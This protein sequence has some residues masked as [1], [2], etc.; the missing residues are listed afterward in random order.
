MNQKIHSLKKKDQTNQNPL[1]FNQKP[2]QKNQVLILDQSQ[3]TFSP[4]SSC[5]IERVHL[6]TC[7][8]EIQIWATLL[9]FLSFKYS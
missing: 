7:Q 1:K 3:A 4:N 9:K 2:L 5:S 8:M 6:W